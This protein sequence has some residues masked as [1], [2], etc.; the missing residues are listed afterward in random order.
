MD[1]SPNNA[2]RLTELEMSLMHL[3][4]DFEMLNDVVLDNS[5]RLQKLTLMLQRL[6]DRLDRVNENES[7]RNLEDERPPHY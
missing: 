4:G 6:T 5:Q 7:P 1:P 2:N 3:Q